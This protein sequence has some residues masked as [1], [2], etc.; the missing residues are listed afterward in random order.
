MLFNYFREHTCWCLYNTSLYIHIL[1]QY[2]RVN[3]LYNICLYI[4]SLSSGTHINYFTAS[5]YIYVIGHIVYYFFFLVSIWPIF[6]WSAFYTCWFRESTYIYYTYG[7][8]NNIFRHMPF[9][10][11]L[12]AFLFL[13]PLYFNILQWGSVANKWM[14]V[15]KHRG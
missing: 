2:I 8:L 1:S 13:V 12:L 9:T 5:V 3:S 7:I 11:C 4:F 15:G 6:G 10:F 14:N